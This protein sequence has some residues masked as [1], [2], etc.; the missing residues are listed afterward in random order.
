MAHAKTLLKRTH[1]V[2]IVNRGQLSGKPPRTKEDDFRF[3]VLPRT[4]ETSPLAANSTAL[5]DE[6][7]K[8]EITK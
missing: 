7:R 8:H 1:D 6:S 2:S 3:V 5:A 4:D